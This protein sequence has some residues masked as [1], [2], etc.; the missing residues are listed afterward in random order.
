MRLIKNMD[1]IMKQQLAVGMC[2]SGD[3]LGEF[4]IYIHILTNF[5]KIFQMFSI[6]TNK[7]NKIYLNMSRYRQIVNGQEFCECTVRS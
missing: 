3:G 2:E 1:L 6:Q 7:N 4:T 5:P